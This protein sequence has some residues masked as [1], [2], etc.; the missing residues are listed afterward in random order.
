MVCISFPYSDIS[1]FTTFGRHSR[2]SVQGKLSQTTQSL[3]VTRSTSGTFER[4]QWQAL[5]KRLVASQAWKTFSMS[6]PVQKDKAVKVLFDSLIKYVAFLSIVN[7]SYG[8]REA[9]VL[10]SA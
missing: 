9:F 8:M 3:Q 2:W 7:A 4:E 6:W 10:L 5:E 1:I